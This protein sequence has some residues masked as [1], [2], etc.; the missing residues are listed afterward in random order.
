MWIMQKELIHVLAVLFT[1]VMCTLQAEN[2]ILCILYSL[3]QITLVERVLIPKWIC[4]DRGTKLFKE[5]TCIGNCIVTN[6]TTSIPVTLLPTCNDHMFG[7][8]ETMGRSLESPDV[9]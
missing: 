3:C 6:W 4:F 2:L 5:R 7:W 1:L 9:D 8:P